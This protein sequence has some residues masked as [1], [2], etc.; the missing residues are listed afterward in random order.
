[1]KVKYRYMIYLV[2]RFLSTDYLTRFIMVLY[3]NNNHDPLIII[4]K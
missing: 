1:M 2:N 3:L 4:N